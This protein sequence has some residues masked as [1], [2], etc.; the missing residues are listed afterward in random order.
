[1]YSKC[2]SSIIGNLGE[3]FKHQTEKNLKKV[4]QLNQNHVIWGWVLKL[5]GI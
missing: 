4:S 1:M 3:E 5:R 2:N